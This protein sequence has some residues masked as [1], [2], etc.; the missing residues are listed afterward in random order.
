MCCLLDLQTR[1]EN[2]DL[3]YIEQA[4]SAIEDHKATKEV[5]NRVV[6]A[7]HAQARSTA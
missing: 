2:R 7:E 1:V 6:K 3:L 4:L 5:V